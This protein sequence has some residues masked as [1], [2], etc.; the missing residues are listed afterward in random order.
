[1]RCAKMTGSGNRGQAEERRVRGIRGMSS[2]VLYHDFTSPFCRLALE[3][4]VQLADRLGTSLATVPYELRPA[5]LPLPEPHD[6]ELMEEL[7]AAAPLASELGVP[8]PKPPLVPRTRKAHEAVFAARS[9][10]E[11]LELV[12]VRALYDAYWSDG[13]DIGR[14]DVLADLAEVAGLD[15]EAIH[16]A[17]GLD[18]QEAAV[19]EAQR[20]AERA[21]V[22]GVPTLRL[23][24]RVL[25]G[26]VPSSELR[27]WAEGV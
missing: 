20:E 12:M 11:D 8:L 10:R 21:G 7:E 5:P 1:M 2:L 25:V 18:E 27:A 4:A 14:I 15:R 22:A 13:A 23:G 26:L 9:Q 19:V 16:V 24:D 3:Q 6:R 17:L